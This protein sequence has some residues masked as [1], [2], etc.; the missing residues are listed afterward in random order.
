MEYMTLKRATS[1]RGT[2]REHTLFYLFIMIL[3][4][5]I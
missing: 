5:L 3:G 4:V 2:K 1:V